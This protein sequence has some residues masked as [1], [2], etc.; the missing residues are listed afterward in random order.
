MAFGIPDLPLTSELDAV[1]MVMK[2]KGLDLVTSIDLNDAEIADAAFHLDTADKEVQSKGWWFNKDYC[3]SL[4]RDSAG[5]IPTPAGTLSV[6]PS[7]FNYQGL[8]NQMPFVERGGFLWDLFNHTFVFTSAQLV[9]ITVRLTYES[10]P[11][12][13]R[14]YI[15][16]LGAHRA[17][18]LDRGNPAT[19]QITNQMV[20]QALT[21]LEWEQDKAQPNNQVHDNISV[22][23]AINGFGGLARGRIT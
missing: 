16:M 4:A 20:I 8:S 22:A 7:Y 23:G 3:L 11:E 5:K 10:C 6:A 13:A 12:V 17:Q 19:L 18:G 15:A 21:A 9:D 14:R 1:N 2:A